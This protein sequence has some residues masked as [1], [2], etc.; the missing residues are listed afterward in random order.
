MHT[1]NA[2]CTRAAENLYALAFLLAATEVQNA[3]T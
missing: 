1:K 2:A 3:R